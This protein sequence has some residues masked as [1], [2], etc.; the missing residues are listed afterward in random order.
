MENRRVSIIVPVFN[1]GK[2]IERCAVSLFEQTY[3]NIEY[4][5]V[6]DCTPDCSIDV[7]KRV[8]SRYPNRDSQVKIIHHEKNR[9]VAASRNTALDHCTGDFVCQIDPDDY[10]ELDAIESLLKCQEQADYDIVTGQMLKHTKD[11]EEL[12]PFPVYASKKDMVIDMMQTTIMHSL[13]N[14]LIKRSLIE[15]NNIRA[16]EGVNCGEDCWMMTRLA[17]YAKSFDTIDKVVYHYDCTR[18][19]SYTANK[20]GVLNKKKIQD[21]IAT[22]ELVIGF[23]KDKEPVY[24]D[25]ANRVAIKYNEMVLK[26]AASVNDFGL[27]DEMRTRIKA[28]DRRYWDAIGRYKG[29]KR[30]MLQ[31]YNTCRLALFLSRVYHKIQSYKYK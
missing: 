13:A 23:F 31:N 28:F 15:D 22:A 27:Y 4:V 8:M 5:F 21:D 2:Y 6:N 17:Y 19:D 20:K 7:L 30:I 29:L 25:E 26:Q 16:E 11:K 24:L 18:D 14:R 1:V 12:L 10:I 3:S 9:G